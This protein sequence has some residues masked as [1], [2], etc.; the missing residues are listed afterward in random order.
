M[1]RVVFVVAACVV[2]W[3]SGPKKQPASTPLERYLA[4]ANAAAVAPA[5]SSPGSIWQPG[6]RLADTGQDLRASQTGDIVTI[7]VVESASAV[8]KGTTRTQRSSS[9]A[10]SV[11]ALAGLTRAAGPL[12]NLTRLSGDQQLAGEGTTSRDMVISTTLAARVTAVLP[13]GSML[14]EAAKDIQINSERQTVIVRGLVRPAD[15]DPDN[16]IRSDRLAD[17][18]LR[19]N[20][21]GIVG[22]AIRRPFILYRVLLGLLPF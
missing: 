13:N 11:G 22:D 6:S 19:V 18:E 20:G 16:T 17:L 15:I 21:K 10:H 8:A 1:K 12:A 14:V 7:L 5:P 4:E 9:A 3:G 2:A